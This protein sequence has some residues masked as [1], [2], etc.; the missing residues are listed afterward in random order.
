VH[1]DASRLE[2]DLKCRVR[3]LVCL[4]AASAADPEQRAVGKGRASLEGLAHA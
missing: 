4:A 2:R 3:G 1:G